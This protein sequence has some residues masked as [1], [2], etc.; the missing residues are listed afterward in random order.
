MLLLVLAALATLVSACSSGGGGSRSD[1]PF[2]NSGRSNT[3]GERDALYEATFRYLIRTE[4]WVGSDYI[5]LGIGDMI[6]DPQA[7]PGRMVSRLSSGTTRVV[8]ATG[9][10]I[11]R[12][13]VQHRTTRNQA[14]LIVVRSVRT[15][16]EGAEAEAFQL[17][18]GLDQELFRCRLSRESGEWKVERCQSRRL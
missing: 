4:R 17:T 14:Q 8:S 13:S 6:Y 9:C 5:C 1:F 16:S 12:S 15:T 11:G 10:T 3:L 2:V 7:P 18:S